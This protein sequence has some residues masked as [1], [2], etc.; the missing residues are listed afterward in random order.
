MSEEIGYTCKRCNKVIEEDN[1]CEC[2]TK[3]LMPLYEEE[4]SLKGKGLYDYPDIDNTIEYYNIRLKEERDH[5][6]RCGCD[7]QSFK[8]IW[9]ELVYLYPHPF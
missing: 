4:W 2:V 9:R 5:E 6:L 8:K 3:R 7:V 1:G